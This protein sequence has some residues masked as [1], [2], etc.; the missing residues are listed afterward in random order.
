MR[1]ERR[2]LKEGR[3]GKRTREGAYKKGGQREGR[4]KKCLRTRR[5]EDRENDKRRSV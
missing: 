1:T 2:N 5:E 3:T 4:E